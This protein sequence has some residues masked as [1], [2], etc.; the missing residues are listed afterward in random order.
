MIPGAPQTCAA[1]FGLK[2]PGGRSKKDI[3]DV[4]GSPMTSAA[5]SIG[6]GPIA[7]FALICAMMA[8]GGCSKVGALTEALRHPAKPFTATTPP[9]AP[10]FDK[11]DAWMAYPGRN[12]MERSTPS[13][14]TAVAE[15]SA[16][17][18]LFF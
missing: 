15:A 7:A 14:V 13:G 8:L 4:E 10:D 1:A 6:R 17:A 9:P 12:G 18:D 2:A 5:R 11:P 3:T 16:P